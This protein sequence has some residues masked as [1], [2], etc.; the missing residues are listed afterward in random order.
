MNATSQAVLSSGTPATDNSR[1][2]DM[3]ED[4]E[5]LKAELLESGELFEDEDFEAEESSIF[6]ADVEGVPDAWRD[7]EWL[8]PSVSLLSLL[9]DRLIVTGSVFAIHFL[10]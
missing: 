6:Y 10:L 1:C 5:T 7:A 3:A 4:Y 9:A 2:T 8:R